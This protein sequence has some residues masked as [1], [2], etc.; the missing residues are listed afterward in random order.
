MIHSDKYRQQWSFSPSSSWYQKDCK[1]A[2]LAGEVTIVSTTE[3]VNQTLGLH[4][5]R[6][7]ICEN[8]DMMEIIIS[9]LIIYILTSRDI[10]HFEKSHMARVGMLHN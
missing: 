9:Q 8:N 4:H 2:Q 5:L 6:S 10:I 3:S 7:L 1:Q